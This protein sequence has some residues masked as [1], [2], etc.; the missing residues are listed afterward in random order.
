MTMA[1]AADRPPTKATM[2]SSSEPL[3]RGS[4]STNMSLSTIA[5][6]KRQQAGERNR[7]HEE[8]DQHQIERKQPGGAFDLSFVVV[9]TTATWNWRGNK[10]IATKDSR[11]MAT[12]VSNGGSR[13]NRGGMRPVVAPR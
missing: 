13:Q 5:R 8:V 9:F 4:A 1:V 11:V 6:R 2:V 7:H 10:M 3:C 12:S